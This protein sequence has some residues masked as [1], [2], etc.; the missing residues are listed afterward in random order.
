L[1]KYKIPNE[2]KRE[3]NNFPEKTEKKNI[4][5][6]NLDGLHR[7]DT[8]K[9]YKQQISRRGKKEQNNGWRNRGTCL[10]PPL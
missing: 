9:N 1:G 2:C 4:E 10:S 8:G 5:I 3:C 7:K 6:N